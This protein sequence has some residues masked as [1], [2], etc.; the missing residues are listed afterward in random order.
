M[1]HCIVCWSCLSLAGQSVRHYHPGFV[2]LYHSHV[3][4]DNINNRLANYDKSRSCNENGGSLR[5][6]ISSPY[7]C[8]EVH[9]S[10]PGDSE[11]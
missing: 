5:L 2:L 8:E 6:D 9:E 10:T 11:I 4:D 3:A 1:R 7:E